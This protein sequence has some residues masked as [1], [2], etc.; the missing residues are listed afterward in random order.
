MVKLGKIVA[1]HGL[2]GSVVLKHN[3]EQQEWLNS[4]DVLHIELQRDNLIPHFVETAKDSKQWE[5]I[6]S[7]DELDNA[8]KA[9]ALI[10]KNV[11]V[12]EELLR[13]TKVNS[14]LLY[15]GFDLV[16]KTKG[17]IGVIADVLQAGPQWIAQLMIDKKEVLVPLVDDFIIDVNLKNKFIRMNLPD[18]LLEVYL[19]NNSSEED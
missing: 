3:I 8:E 16:D 14:P 13:N 15:V 5:C 4:G 6:I 1:T 19:D 12:D 7:L 9:K 17:G 18:G 2:Q 10:G 11:Y